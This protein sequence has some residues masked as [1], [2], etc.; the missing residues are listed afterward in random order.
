M[1]HFQTAEKII[2]DVRKKFNSISFQSISVQ[3]ELCF[4][5]YI[6]FYE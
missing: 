3:N 5:L 1:I 6:S 4:Y 2:T